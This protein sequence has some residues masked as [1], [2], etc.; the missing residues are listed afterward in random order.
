M[1]CIMEIKKEKNMAGKK[2]LVIMMMLLSAAVMNAE[3]VEGVWCTRFENPM[4]NYQ[5]EY[6]SSKKHIDEYQRQMDGVDH[7]SKEYMELKSKV[8]KEEAD[9]NIAFEKINYL[10]SQERWI[11]KVNGKGDSI[12]VYV[13]PNTS[14]DDFLK[15]YDNVRHLTYFVNIWAIDKVSNAKIMYDSWSVK[16]PKIDATLYETNYPLCFVNIK[17]PNEEKNVQFYDSGK[18]VCKDHKSTEG[19]GKTYYSFSGLTSNTPF[20]GQLNIVVV[21]GK[22]IK[23]MQY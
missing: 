2:I 13:K 14:I 23:L 4:E 19:K 16:R 12:V 21:C 3:V 9:M 10:N 7:S 11:V 1:S 6:K 18:D 22:E 8:I 20:E 15:V 17:T 5:W